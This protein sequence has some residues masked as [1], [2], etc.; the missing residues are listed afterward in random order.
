MKSILSEDSYALFLESFD[1]DVPTSI[2]FNPDKISFSDIES[3]NLQSVPWAEHGYYLQERPIFTSNLAYQAGEYYVQEASSMLI[4]QLFK[5]HIS[6]DNPLKI[7]DLC[8][9]PGGKTTHLLTLAHPQ[10]L[11]VSNE[12]IPKRFQILKE[13]IQRWGSVNAILTNR[14]A[15]FLS[16]HLIDFFD[17][18]LV[19][20]P[21]SGEGMFRKDERAIQEWSKAHVKSC[22]LRQ[23][24]I[25]DEA[26]KMLK[27]GGFLI[28]STCTYNVSENQENIAY[29]IENGFSYLSCK[30]DPSWNIVGEN[31]GYQCFPHLVKGEGFFC[32]ILKKE[33]DLNQERKL[34][35]QT[36]SLISEISKNDL[37]RLKDI[38][39]YS[40][41]FSYFTYQN[42]I[43][44]VLNEFM[45]D[46]ILLANLF[47]TSAGLY[48]G[49]FKGNNFIPSHDL[50]LQKKHPNPYPIAQLTY[51]NA[52]KFLRKDN[53]FETIEDISKPGIYNIAFENKILGFAKFIG[54]RWNNYF[55]SELKIRNY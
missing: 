29:L 34:K 18:I 7:L 51:E 17:L 4:E 37:K 14:D 49:E 28:Y 2:R 30:F 20:A 40:S 42:M 3:Q 36:T 10:S 33:V 21:C 8:A 32:C 1:Q 26:V 48:I 16:K 55:P 13:N 19:D 39:L 9:A 25:L 54:T 53:N 44:A 27:V 11:V 23:K 38:G 5:Q 15:N 47:R 31:F 6:S 35:N 12:L 46:R 43:Y 22:S 24:N 50:A 41:L 52:M 45:E